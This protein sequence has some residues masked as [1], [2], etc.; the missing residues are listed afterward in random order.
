MIKTETAMGAAFAAQGTTS[1]AIECTLQLERVLAKFLKGGGNVEHWLIL[2]SHVA[3]TSIKQGARAET[4]AL[5]QKPKPAASHVTEA[6]RAR[7]TR[8][9][10]EGMRQ[11]AVSILDRTRTSAGRPWGDVH[12]YEIAG[13]KRDSKIGE[14]VEARL[15]ALNEKQIQQPLRELLDSKDDLAWFEDLSKS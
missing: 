3:E 15:G 14:A 8:I 11:L 13:M 6:D 10:S 9:A 4:P 1:N 7:S 2:C 12:P 5:H